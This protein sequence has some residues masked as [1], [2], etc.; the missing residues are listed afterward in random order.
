MRL[1]R[2]LSQQGFWTLSAYMAMS[3]YNFHERSEFT[4]VF[5]SETSEIIVILCPKPLPLCF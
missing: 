5:T 1:R 2:E 4:P 3:F